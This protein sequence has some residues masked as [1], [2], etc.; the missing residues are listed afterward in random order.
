MNERAVWKFPFRV[1]DSFE[2][3]M[4]AGAEVLHVEAQFETPCLWALVDPT[5]AKVLRRFRLAGTGHPISIPPRRE[6]KH[7]GTFMLGGGS[8]VFHLFDLGEA[9]P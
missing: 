1:D 2:V 4:P 3:S 5:A 8:L 9:T 7:V 6:F